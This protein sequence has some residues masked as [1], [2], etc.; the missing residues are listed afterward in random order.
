MAACPCLEHEKGNTQPLN[1]NEA[2][3]VEV[4]DGQEHGAVKTGQ[5][6]NNI[7]QTNR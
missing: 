6:R 7:Q 1:S 5:S 2:H 4:A 3:G